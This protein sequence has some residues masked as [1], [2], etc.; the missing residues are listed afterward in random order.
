M[1]VLANFEGAQGVYITWDY[2]SASAPSYYYIKRSDYIQGTYTGVATVAYPIN[3]Y[4]DEAG[5]LESYYIVEELDSGGTVIATHQP[6]WGD[7]MMLRAS[8]AYELD[9]LLRVPVYRERLIFTNDERTEA[10]VAAWGPMNYWPRPRVY[11]SAKQTDGDREP[12]LVVPQRGFANVINEGTETTPDYVSFEWY[13]DYNNHIHF[14]DTAGAPVSVKEYDDVF[15]D[16]TF[17]AITPREM[18]DTIYLAACEIVAQPGVNK[19][20][21]GSAPRQIGDIPRWW[22][23]ALIDG[24][25]YRILRR[26]ALSLNQQ[27]RKIVFRDWQVD[28]DDPARRMLEMAKEYADR[29]KD[30][31]EAIKFAE[32]P[33]TEMVV[34]Q[35][36]MLPGARSR[37]FRMSFASSQQ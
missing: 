2:M 17:Q 7:E 6:M 3:E 23:G 14:V 1:Q 13:N 20:F 25:A 28:G 24:A 9:W 5:S 30:E 21:I 10:H 35:E 33:T 36:Y 27:E 32:Y 26:V 8:L 31:K 18:N 37:F 15:M 12:F 19:G 11:L 4:V 29:F 16:Y 34:G 22:D